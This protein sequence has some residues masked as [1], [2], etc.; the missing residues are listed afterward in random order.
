MTDPSV[1]GSGTTGN[2]ADSGCPHPDHAAG[3]E[4]P[5][6]HHRDELSRRELAAKIWAGTGTIIVTAV[7]GVIVYEFGHGILPGVLTFV[8]AVA[9]GA[10][11]ALIAYY[12]SRRHGFRFQRKHPPEGTTGP[13]PANGGKAAEFATPVSWVRAAALMLTCLA[14][15]TGI[16][17]GVVRA[18][19]WGALPGVVSLLAAAAVV[20]PAPLLWRQRRSW[21]K[22]LRQLLPRLLPR[23]R[24]AQANQKTSVATST[25]DGTTG[26]ITY[27]RARVVMACVLATAAVMTGAELGL[28]VHAAACPGP[29]ELRILATP[30]DLPAIQAAIPAFEQNEQTYAG[31]TCFAVQLT[32]YAPEDA[33]NATQLATDFESRWNS[34]ALSEIGPKPDIW[35]PDS[36]AEVD[37]VE[38]TPPL[39]GPTFGRPRPIGYSPLVIAVPTELVTSDSLTALEQGEPWKTLYSDF[40]HLGIKLALPSPDLSEAGLFE[41]AALYGGGSLTTADER[42]LEAPGNFPQ[43]SQDLLCEA[44]Q[45]TGQPA[46]TVYLV[47]EAA[48]A[49][50]NSSL[51][52]PTENRCPT[53]GQVQPMQAF[54]PAGTATLN[55]PL[56]TVNWGGNQD[57]QRRRYE[58]D[59]FNFLTSPAG[60]SAVESQGLRPPGCGTGGT[61]TQANEIAIFDPSC[62]NPQTPSAAAA[63]SARKAFNQAVP[64]ASVLIGIDDS[65]P[66]KTNLAGIISAIDTVLSPPNAPLGVGDHFGIWELP[67]TGQAT[68]TSLVNFEPVTAANL[69]QIGRHLADIQA[70]QHSADYNMLIDAAKH[71]LYAQRRVLPGT[72]TPPVNSVVLLTD[73]DG[74]SGN[75][76][77]PG[78]GT[79]TK[80]KALFTSPAF[81]ESRIALYIIAFGEAGCMPPMQALAEATNG[82]CYPAD[83]GDPRQLLGKALDQITG[84][85]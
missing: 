21:S 18:F 53:P 54:Y 82:E 63:A 2:G 80:V 27:P 83:G 49:D 56:T 59:F 73:G 67:G 47:S 41:I 8:I 84:G 1:S 13:A 62:E 28:S 19:A 65:E 70:H 72:G 34:D 42:K 52:N 76:P 10:I 79:A 24:K 32:A 12:P 77:G 11:A 61:I 25:P 66:M 75:D 38:S 69:Q 37:A 60:I 46:D 57:A 74:Y 44:S 58:N 71:V 31:S 39:G 26:W 4:G 3:A 9:A 81:G 43:D 15:L 30:E 16:S 45:T 33:P 23:S 55:F 6:E 7:A 48:M 36:T 20:G 5:A 35:I 68:D 17:Y 85:G 40:S 29:A 14:A 22:W 78:D 50:Y 64:N 51:A